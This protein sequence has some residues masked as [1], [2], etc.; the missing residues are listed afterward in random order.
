M[1]EDTALL[2]LL[3]D[4]NTLYSNNLK[5]TLELDSLCRN[6]QDISN[7]CLTYPND[8]KAQPLKYCI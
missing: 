2:S 6:C 1:N 7:S 8:E 4:C 5:F 3:I